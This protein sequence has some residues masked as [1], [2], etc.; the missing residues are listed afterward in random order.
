MW[1]KIKWEKTHFV[2]VYSER[3]T[4]D[5]VT[6]AYGA[7]VGSS[8]FDDVCCGIV[9]ARNVVSVDY[10]AVDF[11]KHAAFSKAASLVRPQLKIGVVVANQR[12][13]QVVLGFKR[14]VE[15]KFKHDWE[16]KVFYDYEQ[17]ISWALEEKQESNKAVE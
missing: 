14:S 12:I 1:V 6:Q 8:K 11:R 9:D 16:R 10:E 5:E 17:A 13:E 15:E 3:I 4:I 7:L 2:L